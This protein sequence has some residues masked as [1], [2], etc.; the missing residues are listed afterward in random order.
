MKDVEIRTHK[1]EII[2][3]LAIILASLPLIAGFSLLVLSSFSKKMV[4]NFDPSSFEFT[5]RNWE[6]L[7]QGKVAI[8]GG[9][10]EDILRYFINTAIVALGVSLLVTIVGTMSGYALSRMKFRY[11]K[12]FL[13]LI[14]LL[15]AFP[16]SV[17][18]VGVYFI[19]RLMVPSYTEF[20]ST[21]SFFYVIIARAAL[22]IPMSTWLMKGFFDLIPWEVEWAAIVDGASRPRVWFQ[23]MLPLVKPGIAAIMLFGFLAG[24]QD[25]IYVRTF[26]VERTLA[27]FIEANLETEYAYMPLVAAAATLYLLPTIIFFITSQQLL[28]KVSLAGVK[29]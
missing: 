7:F 1:T 26:L 24:W 4:T 18:I 17:L 29:R 2:I 16:G 9:L 6:L 27:T 28:L 23:V 3:L 19:Y 14:L 10:T 13:L 20:I 8:T 11:R 25:L 5:L 12:H 21:F 22:E 15:H